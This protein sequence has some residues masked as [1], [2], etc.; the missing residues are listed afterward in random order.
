MTSLIIDVIDADEV[1]AWVDDVI[2][3][4]FKL[5]N[6][7]ED[8]A[9][10]SD[11]ELAL[12]QALTAFYLEYSSNVPTHDTVFLNFD[13]DLEPYLVQLGPHWERRSYENDACPRAD[14][15]IDNYSY[16]TVWFDYENPDKSEYLRERKKGTMFKFTLVNQDD[17]PAV[18][19]DNF[20]DILFYINSHPDF[21]KE[22]IK[23]TFE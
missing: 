19:S 17:K 15:I 6:A 12:K 13:Y 7:D 22:D 21:Y 2:S 1:D 8:P 9:R 3:T 16:W 10:G 5:L 18:E 11:S 20:N 4:L 23:K 14:Y